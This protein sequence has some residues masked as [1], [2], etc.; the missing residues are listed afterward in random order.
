MPSQTR[1]KVGLLYDDLESKFLGKPIIKA[2]LTDRPTYVT[3]PIYPF[4]DMEIY[5]GF[6]L[7]VCI[8]KIMYLMQGLQ[9]APGSPQHTKSTEARVRLDHFLAKNNIILVDELDRCLEI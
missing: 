1:R 6:G 9:A 3:V 7:K 2:M 5:S 8:Q 4:D